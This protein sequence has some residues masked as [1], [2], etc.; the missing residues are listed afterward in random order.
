[1]LLE[2]YEMSKC[3]ILL[4]SCMSFFV[5]LKDEVFSTRLINKVSLDVIF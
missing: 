2:L 3:Y 5:K 1:M 4:L